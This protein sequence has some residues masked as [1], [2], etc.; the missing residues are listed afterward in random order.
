MI[1]SNSQIGSQLFFSLLQDQLT[2]LERY[3]GSTTS[4]V[5]IYEAIEKVMQ[6]MISLKTLFIRINESE[7][8]ENFI[9]TVSHRNS[10]RSSKLNTGGYSR[11]ECPTSKQFPPK[12]VSTATVRDIPPFYNPRPTLPQ[13]ERLQ[14]KGSASNVCL[15][16]SRGNSLMIKNKELFST[17]IKIIA[18]ILVRIRK[19]FIFDCFL[20]MFLLEPNFL[21]LTSIF[22]KAIF[23]EIVGIQERIKSSVEGT[24]IMEEDAESFKD[25]TAARKIPVLSPEELKAYQCAKNVSTSGE[26]GR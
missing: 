25:L 20:D 23:D 10:P 5:I 2:V 3:T 8:R 16:F 4:R 22:T 1:L 12:Y 11:S 7:M 21:R 24:G 17:Y 19:H 13:S 15:L 18:N 26:S 9:R 6:S 14:K